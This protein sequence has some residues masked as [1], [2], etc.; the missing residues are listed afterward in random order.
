MDYARETLRNVQTMWRRPV[1]LVTKV[2]GRGVML[3]FDGREH[4]DKRVDL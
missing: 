4:S 3:R 2:D 1:N